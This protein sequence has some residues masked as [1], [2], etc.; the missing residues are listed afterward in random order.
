[1]S[2]IRSSCSRPILKHPYRRPDASRS[3]ASNSGRLPRQ[4]LPN[5]PRPVARRAAAWRDPTTTGK[6][7]D[8]AVL[9]PAVRI[10][11][12]IHLA[13]FPG[14]WQA[15]PVKEGITA[16]WVLILPLKNAKVGLETRILK[17][18]LVSSGAISGDPSPDS[19][20]SCHWMDH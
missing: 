11:S 10:C 14:F 13:I 12:F 3:Y 19:G 2:L 18:P 20:G 15:K 5:P 1:M 16:P 17:R 4:D 8:I 7:Y 9:P 6:R